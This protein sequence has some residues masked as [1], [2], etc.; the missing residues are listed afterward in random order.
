MNIKTI[1]SKPMAA[2]GIAFLI[3]ASM[4]ATVGLASATPTGNVYAT[5]TGSKTTYADGEWDAG[6]TQFTLTLKISG[7]S[8]IWG[9]GVGSLT[10]NP[11]VVQCTQINELSYLK[12]PYLDPDTGEQVNTF[13]TIFVAGEPDNVLGNNGNGIAD[14][15][16]GGSDQHV[17][18]ASGNLCSIKF[19]I[20]GPGNANIQLTD[21]TL[22]DGTDFV[23]V[24]DVIQNITV[25]GPFVVPEY[26]IGAL[27]AI[28]AAF[29]AFIGFA[30]FKKGFSVPSFSK[31]F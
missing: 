3:L 24:S 5:V 13:N 6:V 25:E 1:K 20:I 15:I 18:A 9:W 26:S 7:A 17:A 29:A 27:M 21:V 22:N 11:A 31:R 30:A 2:I 12:Q 14:A 8:N 16:S 19:T 4:I 23:Y 10:W 28:V